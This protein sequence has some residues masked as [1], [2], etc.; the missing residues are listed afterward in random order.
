[1][2]VAMGKTEDRDWQLFQGDLVW[3]G[4]GN[5]INII[6]GGK[7]TKWVFFKKWQLSRM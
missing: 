5:G 7:G 4:E 2:T 3:R 1:V 6:G